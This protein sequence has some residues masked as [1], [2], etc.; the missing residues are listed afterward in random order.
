MT[1]LA[2][3]RHPGDEDLIRYMDHQLDREAARVAGAH[4]RT[5]ADCAARLE[6]L[7]QRSAAVSGMLA[8]LGGEAPDPGRRAVAMAALERARVRSSATGPLGASWLRAA[9]IVLLL[10]AAAVGTR[11]GR[12]WVAD[13]VVRIYGG[14]PGPIATRLVE[15]LGEERRLGSAERI[16]AAPPATPLPAA[17]ASPPP[18]PPPPAT[19]PVAARRVGLPLGAAP[20]VRFSPPGPDLTLVFRSIQ[21]GGSATLLIRDVE[22]ASGQVTEGFRGEALVPTANGLEVQNRLDSRAEYSITIPTRFRFI[23]LRVGEGR[24]VVI[25]VYKS[26]REWVWTISLRNSALE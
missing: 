4:L 15:W 22:G 1:L 24:E 23:R 3:S 26:K 11:P 25:P 5:C 16:D 9:A 17:E 13:A 7:Q 8:E 2:R 21:A 10:L 6:T 20:P 18:A 12:A 19:A 14:N